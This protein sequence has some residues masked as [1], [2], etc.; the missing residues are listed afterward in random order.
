[1]VHMFSYRNIVSLFFR[2]VII[3]IS[4][5]S[6]LHIQHLLHP[7]KGIPPPLPSRGF[8]LCPVKES[9]VRIEVIMRCTDQG[10]LHFEPYKEHLIGLTCLCF[11]LFLCSNKGKVWTFESLLIPVQGYRSWNASQHAKRARKRNIVHQSIAILY[12]FSLNKLWLS[13]PPEGILHTLIQQAWLK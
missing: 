2:G 4:V 7:G 12:I 10:K 11:N 8:L 13:A 1:M 6:I 9:S 3:V 5:Y